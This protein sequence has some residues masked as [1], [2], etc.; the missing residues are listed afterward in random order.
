MFLGTGEEDSQY[1]Y[2]NMQ[3]SAI[4][5]QNCISTIGSKDDTIVLLFLDIRKY[6]CSHCI[7]LV[8]L[9]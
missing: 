2:N 9:I 3:Q 5:K 6:I 8:V 4:R 7:L 1:A